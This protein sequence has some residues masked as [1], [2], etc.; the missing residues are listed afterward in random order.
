MIALARTQPDYSTLIGHRLIVVPNTN[1]YPPYIEGELV[2]V[3]VGP[4]WVEWLIRDDNWHC[5]ALAYSDIRSWEF[6][7][8]RECEDESCSL[9]EALRLRLG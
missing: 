1:D 3:T 6:D 5:W 9:S 2:G 7:D 8:V 4:G